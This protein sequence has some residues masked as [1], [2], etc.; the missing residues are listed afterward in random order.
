[1]AISISSTKIPDTE[2]LPASQPYSNTGDFR[3][4][5]SYVIA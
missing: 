3:M 4:L 1:M 2:N 5:P